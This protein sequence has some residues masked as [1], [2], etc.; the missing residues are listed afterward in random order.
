MPS[1]VTASA[2]G[3][4]MLLGEHAVVYGHPCLVTA[5]DQRM[6]ATVECTDTPIFELHAPDVK[7]EKYQQSIDTLMTG[8]VPKGARF[9]EQALLFYREAHP[10]PGGVRV[11]T[12]SD[13]SPLF[14]FG[15][16]S[17]STV[18]F[19][20]A[21][22][23]VFDTKLHPRQLFELAYK[24]VLTVQGKGS[25]F[26]V[27]SAAWG[28]TMH[29]AR[30]GEIADPMPDHPFTL[31]VGYTGVKADTV[32]IVTSVAEIA[33]KDQARV[34]ALYK[35]MGELVVQAHGAFITQDWVQ[36]GQFMNDDQLLLSELGVSSDILDRLIESANKGG[37]LG[38]KLSGA[39]IGDCMIALGTP[40]TAPSIASAIT[41]AG[42]TVIPVRVHAPGARVE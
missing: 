39:G 28:G 17:A 42:G 11:T 35:K 2:P 9:I 19:L 41:E 12:S 13:F 38:A 7:I 23:G 1:V 37:A 26:D 25:G 24:T 14:G 34:D 4:L 32:S 6:R 16:S 8:A 40:E 15:S 20:K 3:K 27:A 21:V 36:F 33:K 30:G 29:Y 5:V 18:A 10:F 22:D 31:I